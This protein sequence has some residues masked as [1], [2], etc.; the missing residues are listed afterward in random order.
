MQDDWVKWLFIIEFAN[1]NN[2]STF[3]NVSLFYI[4]KEFYPRMSFSSDIIDYVITQKRL[5]VIKTKDIIDR[6][7]DV[8]IYIREKMN[9]A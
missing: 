4:N 6:M 7:Q 8:F 5:D 3:I 2:V 9:K 1:N